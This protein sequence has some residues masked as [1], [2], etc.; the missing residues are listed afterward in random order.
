MNTLTFREALVRLK[1]TQAH[2][3]RVLER[4]KSTVNRWANGAPIPHEVAYLLT[5]CLTGKVTLAD[6]ERMHLDRL[7][8]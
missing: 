1:I 3:C 8:G 2:L 6:I 4:D 7:H 5:L